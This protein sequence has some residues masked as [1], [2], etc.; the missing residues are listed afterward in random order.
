M[1]AISSVL[2]SLIIRMRSTICNASVAGIPESIRADVK[3]AL[4]KQAASQNDVEKYL[5]QKLGPLV[6][7]SDAEVEQGLDEESKKKIADSAA[8]IAELKKQRLEPGAR[9]FEALEDV[10]WALLNT[11]EFLFQH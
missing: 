4:D 8:K 2:P 10:C 9:R 5:V 3:A 7:V 1:Y 6:A 11:N